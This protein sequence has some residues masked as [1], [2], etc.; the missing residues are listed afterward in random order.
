MSQ[1]ANGPNLQDLP[2]C[3][4]T[5]LNAA[6]HVEK[7][8]GDDQPYRRCVARIARPLAHRAEI[9]SSETQ[10]PRFQLALVW[11]GTDQFDFLSSI[12]PGRGTTRS[13]LGYKLAP[14]KSRLVSL[15]EGSS[16]S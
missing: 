12:V 4:P 7:I 14:T 6:L 15:W 1:P 9:S 10:S 5:T 16:A 11:T 13:Q 3:L 2:E 8:I